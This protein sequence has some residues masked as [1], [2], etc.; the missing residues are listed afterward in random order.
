MAGR[1]NSKLAPLSLLKE[2]IDKAKAQYK[3]GK[4]MSDN[5]KY[6]VEVGFFQR[7]MLKRIQKIMGRNDPGF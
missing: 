4:K 7:L 3:C 2:K 1:G 6:C 5:V